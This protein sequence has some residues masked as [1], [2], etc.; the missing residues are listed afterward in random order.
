MNELWRRLVFLFRHREFNRELEEEMRF[1]LDMKEQGGADA[2]AAR[3]QF[4][5]FTLLKEVS[6]EMWG[7]NSLEKLLQDLRYALRMMRR[8]PGFA[9]IVVATLALGI[10]ANTA[11]FSVVDGVLLRPL[12]FAEP[13]R[14]VGVYSHFAPANM[15]HGTFSVADFLDLRAQVK[16]FDRFAAYAGRRWTLTGVDQPEVLTGLGVTSSFFSVLGAQP[17]L[18]R[19]F[20]DGEDKPNST[21]LAV[22]SEGLWRRRFNSDPSVVGRSILLNGSGSTVV[23]V[24]PTGF[25]FLQ[26][27]L[28]LWQLMTLTPPTQRFPFFLR[29]IAHLKPGVTWEQAQTE[30]NS[31]A[32]GIERSDPKTYSHLSFPVLPLQE[33]L[34][35]NVR[36]ALLVLLGAVGMVLLIAAVNVANL[37]L[38]R[39]ASR[40]R[41]I[42]I[43]MSIGASRV[44]L[45]RQLLTESLL[46]ALAGGTAGVLLARWAVGW[47]RTLTVANVPRLDEVHLDARVLA[48]TFAISVLC[49]VA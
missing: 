31:L 40:E 33:A 47:L 26:P 27:G 41:E 34:V 46:L 45:V 19:T 48:F 6:R 32:P 39:A 10:G 28:D 30:L 35:G 8:T 43:R 25:S 12:P 49:G 29:G 14:L 24:M 13:D 22:I 7:W 23:G 42:A 18:G 36:L 21:P 38:A 5:N 1:H 37:L 3:L 4:G 20:L 9:A 44:R 2:F 17:L 11:I 16:S 15:V